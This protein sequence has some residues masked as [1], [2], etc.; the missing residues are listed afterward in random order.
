MEPQ[1]TEVNDPIFGKMFEIDLDPDFEPRMQALNFLVAKNHEIRQAVM[2]SMGKLV[3]VSMS[4][5]VMGEDRESFLAEKVKPHVRKI[6]QDL[7]DLGNS[8]SE[9]VG[10][11]LM[12]FTMYMCTQFFRDPSDARCL[13]FAWDGIGEWMA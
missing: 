6:G 1:F 3:D 10:F 4:D 12:Q 9:G 8:Y 13:E 11:G 5:T 2:D 7:N